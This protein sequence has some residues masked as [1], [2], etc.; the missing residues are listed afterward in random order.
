[1]ALRGDAMLFAPASIEAVTLTS[2]NQVKSTFNGTKVNSLI[3]DI[4]V[5]VGFKF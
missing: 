4:T 2:S 1:M 3:G 5:S